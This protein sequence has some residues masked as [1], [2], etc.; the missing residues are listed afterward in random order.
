MPIDCCMPAS[1]NNSYGGA[2]SGSPSRAKWICTKEARWSRPD[3][4]ETSSAGTCSGAM[5]SVS[6]VSGDR[7]E[8]TIGAVIVDPSRSRTPVT[9]PWSTR[10]CSTFARN[11]IS[12]PWE[13]KSS[14]R[15]SVSAP[16]P[17]LSLVIMAVLL[18]GTA[19]A[20]AK[21]VALPGVYGPR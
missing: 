13:T 6:V 7:L 21:Q 14:R 20:N 15:C 19:N 3:T 11:L 5:N 1:F 2:N 9:A 18:S 12:P 8:T 4:R 17:P 16:M 10:I